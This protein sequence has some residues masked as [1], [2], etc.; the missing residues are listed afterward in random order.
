MGISF[1]EHPH[2]VGETYGE[3]FMVATRFGTA[4]LAGGLACMVHAVLP[5]LCTSTGSQTVKRLHDRMVVNRVRTATA[6]ETTLETA[7]G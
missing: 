1:T 4:M 2:K 6:Q 3:H 7:Q 5:F